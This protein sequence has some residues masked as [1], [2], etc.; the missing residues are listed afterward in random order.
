MY[1]TS[2]CFLPFIIVH[3]LFQV[4]Y[5]KALLFLSSLMILSSEPTDPSCVHHKQ[6]NTV[7]QLQVQRKHT[8]SEARDDFRS[9]TFP[10]ERLSTHSI[11]NIQTFEIICIHLWRLPHLTYQ[12]NCKEI[13]STSSKI[14]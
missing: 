10:F 2:P 6:K 12:K 13:S 11:F 5:L 8:F 14:V 9:S 3:I 4:P 1:V 7:L